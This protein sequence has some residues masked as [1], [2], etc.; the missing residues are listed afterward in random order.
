MDLS[1]ISDLKST[2]LDPEWTRM[3]G[4]LVPIFRTTILFWFQSNKIQVGI[5]GVS[6][7]SMVISFR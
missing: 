5:C 1:A 4:M 6:V 3:A 7:V 2:S